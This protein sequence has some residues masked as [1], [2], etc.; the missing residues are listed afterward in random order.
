MPYDIPIDIPYCDKYTLYICNYIENNVAI[1]NLKRLFY[2][3]LL[4]VIIC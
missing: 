4:I 3:L 1:D 2:F